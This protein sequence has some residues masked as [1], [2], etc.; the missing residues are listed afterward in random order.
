M[1]NAE[2]DTWFDTTGGKLEIILT[3]EQAD[4][5]VNSKQMHIGGKN[6]IVTKITY[7]P[8]VA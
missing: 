1:K 5:L 2:G 6:A 4:L 3:A 8:I 7:I